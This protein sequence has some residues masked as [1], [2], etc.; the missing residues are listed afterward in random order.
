MLLQLTQITELWSTLY[1]QFYICV[2]YICRADPTSS[3]S[4]LFISDICKRGLLRGWLLGWSGTWNPLSTKSGSCCW[5]VS[6]GERKTK[7]KICQLSSTP[8]RAFTNI[9]MDGSMLFQREITRII[10]EILTIINNIWTIRFFFQKKNSLPY[11]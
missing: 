7:V 1:S 6:L 10:N 5:L 4:L 3:L 9:Q 11:K 8:W 2:S